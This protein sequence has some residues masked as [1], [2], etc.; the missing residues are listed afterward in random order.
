M[1]KKLLGCTALAGAVLAASAAQAAEAPTWKLTG[2]ANFQAYWVDQ[3]DLWETTEGFVEWANVL[4]P[5]IP[6]HV[7]TF[8]WTSII[9]TEGVEVQ[10]HDWYFGVDEAELQLDVSGTADNGLNY[11]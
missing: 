8:P 5:S 6:E 11:G 1:K 2:N 9:N 4:E 10:A 7:T 3:H